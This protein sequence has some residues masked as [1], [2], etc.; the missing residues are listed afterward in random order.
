MNIKKVSEGG[1]KIRHDDPHE[2]RWYISKI[3]EGICRDY[4]RVDD[5]RS[6]ALLNWIVS[7][8]S[9]F[10]RKVY[11]IFAKYLGWMNFK[12]N[13]VGTRANRETWS[14]A[15]VGYLLEALKQSQRFSILC[16]R[17]RKGTHA[18]IESN[19]KMFEFSLSLSLSSRFLTF[20]FRTTVA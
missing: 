5:W 20:Y 9:L 12:G 2:R 19:N 10:F 11:D 17:W 8:V 14:E 7:I 16:T 13:G 6:I 3:V 1:H 4:V 18:Q 15:N